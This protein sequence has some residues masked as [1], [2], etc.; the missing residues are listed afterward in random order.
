MIF[1]EEFILHIVIF[2]EYERDWFVCQDFV[3]MH[4]E[5]K[6]QSLEVREQAP[7]HLKTNGLCTSLGHPK[8]V[9]REM[10]G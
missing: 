2:I 5:G 4:K 8:P 9:A 1:W 3:S 7:S 10:L 6:F